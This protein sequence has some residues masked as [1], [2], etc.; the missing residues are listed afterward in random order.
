MK[1]NIQ[2]EEIDDVRYIVK[3]SSKKILVKSY[4]NM[5]R[6]SY[7][8]YVSI[9]KMVDRKKIYANLMVKNIESAP[10][11]LGWLYRESEIDVSGKQSIKKVAKNNS[12]KKK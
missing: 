11:R 1:K 7:D 9:H 10:F 2:Y 6:N 3:D 12:K 5:V 4:Q 8:H